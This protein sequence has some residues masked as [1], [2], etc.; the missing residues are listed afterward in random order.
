[1]KRNFRKPLVIAGPKTLLRHPKCLSKFEEMSQI[2]H[3]QRVLHYTNKE[4]LS[5]CKTLLLCSGKYVYDIEALLQNNK[6]NNVSLITVEE[7]FPFP[8]E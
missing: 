3:F 8:E 1:M 5:S 2:D 7:L 6:I 4:A